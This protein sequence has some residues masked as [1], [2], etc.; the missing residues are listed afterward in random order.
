VTE[1]HPVPSQTVCPI[2]NIDVNP[3]TPKFTPNTVT[4][5]LLTIASKAGLFCVCPDDRS[6]IE[7]EIMEVALPMRDRPAVTTAILLPRAPC[8]V[9]HRSAVS[10]AHS[11]PSHAVRAMLAR[12]DVEDITKLAPC[13][14]MLTEPVPSALVFLNVLIEAAS[15]VNTLLM[16]AINPIMVNTILAVPAAA[17]DDFT[18]NVESDTHFVFSHKVP[19]RLTTPE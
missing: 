18:R 10:D 14:V 7:Y 6:G 4:E 19:P 15:V 16:L 9:L 11:V 2:L 5:E 13:T 12:E 1:I 3:C 17:A 8:T